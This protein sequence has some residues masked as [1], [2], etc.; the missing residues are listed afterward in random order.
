MNHVGM[1]PRL[2]GVSIKGQVNLF[3]FWTLLS[4]LLRVGEMALTYSINKIEFIHS[5]LSAYTNVANLTSY[6]LQYIQIF[7][8][9]DKRVCRFR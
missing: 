1:C 6:K 2:G 4:F 7:E 9:E 5:W 8:T 3:Q